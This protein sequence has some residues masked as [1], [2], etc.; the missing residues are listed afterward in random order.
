MATLYGISRKSNVSPIQL[1]DHAYHDTQAGPLLAEHTQRPDGWPSSPRLVKPTIISVV[2]DLAV[3]LI[4]LSFSLLFLAFALTVQH[5]D[6]A[7]ISSNPR[8]FDLLTQ[9][10]RYVS[11]AGALRSSS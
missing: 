3:D 4:L 10:T 7:S 8:V 9:A 11:S 2:S 1:Q 5:Y 6:Q